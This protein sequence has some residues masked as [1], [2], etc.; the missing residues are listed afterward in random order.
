VGRLLAWPNL[1]H[2]RITPF[3]LIDKTKSGHRSFLTLSLVDP[4]YRLCSTRNVPPQDHGW[5]AE[6]A[7]SAALPTKVSVPQELVDHI[8]SY[9]DNW[10][11][12]LEEAMEFREQMAKEQ[13]NHERKIMNYPADT[14]DFNIDEYNSGDFPSLPSMELGSS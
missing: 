8:D 10:P 5:W 7:I 2:H 6:E 9:T 11:M 14:Y 13:K 4:S 1:L 12:G 3:E